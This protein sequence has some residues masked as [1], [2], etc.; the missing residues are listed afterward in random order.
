MDIIRDKVREN[1]V[2][3]RR[4]TKRI[5]IF[6]KDYI[7]VPINA[8]KHWYCLIIVHPGDLINSNLNNKCKIIYCDSMFEKRSFIAEALR[9]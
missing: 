2:N 3:V 4:W 5:D 8:F 7:V 1:Y 6:E 9:M